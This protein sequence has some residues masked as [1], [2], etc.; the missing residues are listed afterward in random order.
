MKRCNASAAGTDGTEG[1]PHSGRK[2]SSAKA[3]AP[4]PTQASGT[5]SEAM[6]EKKK[7]HPF[8]LAVLIGVFV[9]DAF[10][11]SF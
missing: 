1:T 8:F 11:S 6:G 3:A 9:S 10:S 2:E 7:A 4:T 5:V